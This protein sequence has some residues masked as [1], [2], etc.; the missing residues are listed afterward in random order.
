MRLKLTI[1]LSTMLLAGCASV[2]RPVLV[3]GA[4]PDLPAPPAVAVDAL[5]AA[6][7]EDPETAAWVID[8]SQHYDALDAARA[9]AGR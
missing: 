4:V 7:L 6:A 9:T 3:T 8:L 2:P 5:E 1:V